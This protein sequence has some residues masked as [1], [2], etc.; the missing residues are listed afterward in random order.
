MKSSQRLKPIKKIA[1]NKEKKAAQSLGKSVQHCQ[2]QADKLTQLVSYRIEYVASMSAKTLQGIS[3]DQLQQ[4]HQFLTKL[5]IAI[6]Q[7]QLVVQQSEQQLSQNQHQWQSDNSRASAIA[8]V[9]SKL[10]DKEVQASN[11]EEASQHD[12]LSTQA[13]LRAKRF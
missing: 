5:D 9:I 11:K 8:K 7:Q 3:G 12:E 10:K 6:G 1:D 2:L 4:Y 13:F